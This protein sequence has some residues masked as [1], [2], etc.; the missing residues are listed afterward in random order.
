MNLSLLRLART[1]FRCPITPSALTS[2]SSSSPYRHT[3]PSCLKIAHFSSNTSKNVPPLRGDASKRK[4]KPR[5]SARPHNLVNGAGVVTAYCVRNAVSLRVVDNA[6]R[7]AV[8]QTGRTERNHDDICKPNSDHDIGETPNTSSSTPIP[9]TFFVEGV[10]TF[11]ADVV[12]A[13]LRGDDNRIGHAFLFRS[14]AAVIWG[15]PLTVRTRLLRMLSAA[16]NGA[17]RDVLD[18]PLPLSEFD[19][20]FNYSVHRELSHVTFRADEIRVPNPV[21]PTALLAVSYGLA[22]SVRLLALEEELDQL[23]ARTRVLPE[24][25]AEHGETKL[26]H[27]AVKRLVGE[28][29]MARYRLNLVED[30]LDTPEFFW[31][32]AELERVHLECV[33]EVELRERV[34]I[35]NTRTQVIKDVLD[36]L[37]QE[38]A[39]S[40]SMRVER[41]ILFLI[42]VEVAMEL[43]KAV[44][45][46]ST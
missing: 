22:Q 17:T 16:Q 32:F 43:A 45:V 6:M 8:F 4:L 24:E 39:T 40:A 23:V 15:L 38:V 12:H 3:I 29:L 2:S 41:A 19:H 13:T 26:P 33:R 35:V 10:Q 11:F 31:Q 46:I 28:L 25:L 7:N 18:V 36:L 9:K 30:I 37:N 14:G 20:E 5:T 27:Q 1:A 34:R 44:V 42:A 21:E